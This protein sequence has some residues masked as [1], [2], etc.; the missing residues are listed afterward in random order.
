LQELELLL[1]RLEQLWT[2]EPFSPHLTS[3]RVRLAMTDYA[4]AVLL[5]GLIP[6]C[7]RIAPGLCI[8]V[9]PWY[10]RSYEDLSAATVDLVFSPL[11]D[12][13]PFRVN[14]LFEQKFVCLLGQRHPFKRKVLSLKAYLS[15]KHVSVETQPMQQN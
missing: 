11:A 1:P 13:P 14:P 7:D 12:P 9:T 8:E 10:E 5:P 2:G 15:Y 3:G 6:E 4:A